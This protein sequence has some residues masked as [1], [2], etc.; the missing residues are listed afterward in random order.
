M[1]FFSVIIPAYNRAHCLPAAIDSVIQQKFNDFELIIVDDGSADDTAEMCKQ[2][3]S[4]IIFLKQENKGVCAAR[5]LGALHASG[6]FLIF[7]DSDDTVTENWLSDFYRLLEINNLDIVLCGYKNS[8]KKSHSALPEK[9]KYLAG[10]FCINKRVFIKAGMYDPVLA[11]GENTELGWRLEMITDKIGYC[12]NANLLYNPS[13]TGGGSNKLKKL[14]SFYYIVNKHN[15]YFQKHP[16]DAQN[17]Y[18]VAAIVSLKLK[19]VHEARKLFVSGYFKWP[20][21][22]KALFRML[23]GISPF[24]GLIFSIDK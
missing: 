1:P 16:K 4:S 24:A 7:L 12:S 15:E 13:I 6:E 3:G 14:E 17:Y 10:S 22:I 21:N 9:H 18:H 2:Y 5:N 20:Y 8:F 23:A 11:Y 19:Q